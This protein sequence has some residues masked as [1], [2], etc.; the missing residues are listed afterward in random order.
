MIIISRNSTYLAEGNIVVQSLQD[1]LDAVRQAGE[2]EVFIIGGGQIF[3]Q[4]LPLAE[5]IYLTLVHA[6]VECDTFFPRIDWD[7]WQIIQEEPLP[8]DEKNQYPTTFRVLSR[9]HP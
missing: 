5:R 9:K 3:T 6:Q 7:E 8:A 4:S 1:A 2:S